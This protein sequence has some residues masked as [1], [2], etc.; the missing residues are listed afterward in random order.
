LSFRNLCALAKVDSQTGDVLWQLGGKRS[1]FAIVGD[2]LGGFAGQHSV[3]VLPSGN[4]LIFDNG[5]TH[6]PP[7]SRAV[8]YSLDMTSM[9]A[10]MVWQF[11]HSPAIFTSVTGSVERLAN[12]NTLVAFAEAGV[13]DEVD[14]AG[15]GVFE[16]RVTN[17]T[18]GV[19]LYRIRRLPSLYAYQQP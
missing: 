2:P 14:P 18:T 10:T 3:R 9:T 17:G 8:E 15:N 11:R 12:G 16:A 6:T 1:Q 19:A 7:E 13:V 5:T 4:V